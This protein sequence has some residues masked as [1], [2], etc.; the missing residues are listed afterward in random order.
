MK[1][2]RQ[3]K[4]NWKKDLS[5]QI[6]PALVVGWLVKFLR[7]ECIFRRKIS[8]AVVGLSG[9]VDSS[10]TAAL[11]VRAFGP[12]NVHVFMMPY[13]TSSPKSYEDAFLFV[14]QFQVPY[15]VIEVTDM[16]DGYL[17]SEPDITPMRLGNVCS[18]ARM[19]ILYDQAAKLGAL[20][21]GT[22]N[23]TE[24]LVG[25]YTWHGDD[26]PPVNPLGDLYK[27]QIWQ[28]ANE[29]S[30][31]ESI[32][33][34]APTADLIVGQTDE[35]DLGINLQKLDY[36]LHLLIQN[37]S[38]EQIVSHGL[39]EIEVDLVWRLL[40]KTHWKR[41]L[42]TVAMLSSNAINEYYLRPVDY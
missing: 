12:E 32:I 35:E 36:I 4:V 39:S 18:R 2:Y 17:A 30:I 20:P 26:A 1:V 6:N 8:K 37:Y 28:I 16:V 41:H 38:A 15:R 10:V 25:Y 11:C 22:S 21:I 31:P 27:T 23:K 9:G 5:L 13:K 14:K 33:K 40:S 29:L 34:K 7:Y 19:I 3:Q 42:P 24:R